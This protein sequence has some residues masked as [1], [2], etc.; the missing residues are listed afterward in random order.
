MIVFPNCKINIGLYITGKRPDG[1]HNLETVFFPVPLHDALEILPN[2]NVSQSAVDFSSTGL[3]IDGDMASNLCVKA[4]HLLANRYSKIPPIKMHLHKA[5]PMGAGLGG[6]SSDASFVLSTLNNLFKLEIEEETLLAYALELGS[7]C[8][9]FIKNKPCL[10]F[11]RGEQMENISIDLTQYDL[12]LV[13]PGIHINTGWAFSQLDLS[14]QKERLSL[15][16]AIN[17]PVTSWKQLIQ[18]DFEVPAMQLHPEINFIKET[19]YKL[20]AVYA[21][22]SGSGSTVYGLFDKEN[23]IDESQWMMSPNYFIKKIPL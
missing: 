5:I 7:D 2:N 22:M 3:D 13:N 17:E 4:Y 12:V 11:E 6:G 9:F 15:R 19:L 1:Y 23:K 21:S 16:T 20:G 18:N 14:A 8:P 10:A